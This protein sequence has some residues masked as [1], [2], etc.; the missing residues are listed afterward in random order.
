MTP[1]C[2]VVLLHGLFLRGKMYPKGTRATL[3]RVQPRT[4]RTAA[5]AVILL[6]NRWTQVYRF[7]VREWTPLWAIAEAAG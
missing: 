1:G 3:N 6:E 2:E 7:D 4:D 5:Y